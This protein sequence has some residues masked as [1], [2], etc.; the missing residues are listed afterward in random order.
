MQKVEAR[1][2]NL[3][4]LRRRPLR[5]LVCDTSGFSDA[6]AGCAARSRSLGHAASSSTISRTFTQTTKIRAKSRL[7]GAGCWPHNSPRPWSPPTF[8]EVVGHHQQVRDVLAPGM[9]K[10]DAAPSGAPTTSAS[11]RPMKR[12]GDLPLSRAQ[13]IV[14]RSRQ[15]ARPAAP[16][17]SAGTLIY[18]THCRGR[19]PR[20]ALARGPS[21]AIHNPDRNLLGRPCKAYVLG[22][23]V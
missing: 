10:L 4:R 3:T 16:R 12:L 14:R 2:L 9:P 6:I 1:N 15:S 7:G 17:C 19:R 21:D 23:G 13:G 5:L 22:R 20:G 18:N 8:R 11:R